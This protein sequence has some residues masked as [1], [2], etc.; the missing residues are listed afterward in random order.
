MAFDLRKARMT[1]EAMEWFFG[2]IVLSLLAGAIASNKGRGFFGC[3]VIALLLSRI[4]ACGARARRDPAEDS[5]RHLRIRYREPYQTRHTF[6]SQALMA[7]ANPM[8]VARQLG[9]KNM[10]MLLK[11]YGKW[12]DRADKSREVGKLNAAFASTATETATTNVSVDLTDLIPLWKVGG[13]DGTRTR[14]PRRDR[15]V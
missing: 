2:W 3:F 11:A 10:G 9:H 1:G 15:P 13:V 6:A 14:D 7:G 5:P 4:A 12:I 8:W